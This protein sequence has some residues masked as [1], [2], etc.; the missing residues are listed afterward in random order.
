VVSIFALDHVRHRAEPLKPYRL[1]GRE[2]DGP[3]RRSPRPEFSRARVSDTAIRSSSVGLMP[4][5]TRSSQQPVPGQ[6][7]R[8]FSSVT[9][10]GA[11]LAVDVPDRALRREPDLG[12]RGPRLSLV[13]A[14]SSILKIGY[15]GPLAAYATRCRG[16]PCASADLSP[17]ADQSFE[18]SGS[19]Y[20]RT[21]KLSS[22]SPQPVSRP[23]LVRQW[24]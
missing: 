20:A 18:R 11:V 1:D 12:S 4:W 24:Q 17:P 19:V 21:R 13:T 23:S 14:G 6:S 10:S 3:C 16:F 8:S 22:D 5:P 2:L 7:T 9:V 15:T